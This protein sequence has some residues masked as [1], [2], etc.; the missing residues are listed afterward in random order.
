LQRTLED[1]LV[2]QGS[3]AALLKIDTNLGSHSRLFFYIK[4]TTEE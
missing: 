4:K 2:G 1:Y 3:L